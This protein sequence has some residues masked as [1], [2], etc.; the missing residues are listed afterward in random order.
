MSS[1]WT[2]CLWADYLP[3]VLSVLSFSSPVEVCGVMLPGHHS[4]CC[5]PPHS[6]APDA[7]AAALSLM[8][9]TKSP[10]KQVVKYLHC[11]AFAQVRNSCHGHS[12]MRQTAIVCARVEHGRTQL[13]SFPIKIHS[14]YEVR[15]EDEDYKWG[16]PP[17]QGV[18]TAR[19]QTPPKSAPHAEN[20]SLL[21]WRS[22]LR[23]TQSC[24]VFA[25][26]LM[27][28]FKTEACLNSW[29]NYWSI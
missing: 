26:S 6:T 27:S 3:S 2:H 28:H 17:E 13:L 4:W 25:R 24:Q 21:G 5:P 1:N 23:W 20:T 15:R 14:S 12:Q 8:V 10:W 16:M 7:P 22:N 9:L 11:S 29:F 18:L 19:N